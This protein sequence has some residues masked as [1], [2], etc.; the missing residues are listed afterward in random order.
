MLV[1]ELKIAVT[2]NGIHSY[3]DMIKSYDLIYIDDFCTGCLSLEAEGMLA[4]IAD[5]LAGKV[6]FLITSQHDASSWISNYFI[7]QGVGESFADRIYRPALRFVLEGPSLRDRKFN[8]LTQADGTNDGTTVHGTAIHITQ[9]ENEKR[10][11][12]R[13]PKENTLSKSDAISEHSTNKD[14]VNNHTV[15]ENTDSE[16][17]TT[18]YQIKRRG[19][20]PK[21]IQSADNSI[22]SQPD[23]VDGT[24]GTD[25]TVP[26]SGTNGTVPKV[27]SKKSEKGGIK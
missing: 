24:Y 14:D 18:K 27:P 10:R 4:E 15:Q 5:C 9:K 7:T 23:T 17:G 22:Y 12:G 25:G 3:L 19:R 26:S 11:R 1:A 2:T 21:N 6:S 8:E 13:P 16:S 20:P